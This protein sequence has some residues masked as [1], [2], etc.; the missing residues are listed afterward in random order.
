LSCANSRL[1]RIVLY[2]NEQ[3]SNLL[4]ERFVLHWQSVRPVPRVMIDFGDGR[5]MERTLT[6]NSI[7]YVLDSE[8][9]VIDALPGMYGPSAFL[10]ELSRIS[11]VVETLSEVRTDERNPALRRYRRAVR[12]HQSNHTR[13]ERAT[14]FLGSCSP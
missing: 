11:S 7:H 2:A 10:R 3:V 13:G 8:G 1:F 6:G 14:L 9:R 4:R 5:K 12:R